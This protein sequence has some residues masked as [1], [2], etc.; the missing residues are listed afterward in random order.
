M[1][2]CRAE[3]FSTVHWQSSKGLYTN[4]HTLQRHSLIEAHLSICSLS[5]QRLIQGD[6]HTEIYQNCSSTHTLAVIKI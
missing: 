2:D 3:Q 5:W 6:T 1:R 4:T